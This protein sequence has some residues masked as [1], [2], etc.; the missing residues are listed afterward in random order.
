MTALIKI[1]NNLF[2]D[3]DIWELTTEEKNEIM[4]IYNDYH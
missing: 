1:A 4:E 2:P 3:R